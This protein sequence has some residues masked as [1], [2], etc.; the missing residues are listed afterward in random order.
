MAIFGITYKNVIS[1]T[2]ATSDIRTSPFNTI[3][4]GDSTF[5]IDCLYMLVV[6][7]V[8]SDG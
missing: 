4:K 5:N 1:A 2:S 3:N 7:K 6:H 8:H